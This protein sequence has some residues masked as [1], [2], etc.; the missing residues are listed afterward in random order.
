M[1]CLGILVASKQK[2]RIIVTILNKAGGRLKT[3]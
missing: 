1:G 3:R 2:K